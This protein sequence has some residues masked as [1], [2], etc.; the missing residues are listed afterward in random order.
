[1]RMRSHRW[2]VVVGEPAQRS[3]PAPP[4]RVL[5]PRVSTS[6]SSPVPPR[7][8][9][10]PEPPTSTSSPEAPPDRSSSPS[11]PNS[12][13]LAALPRR[14]SFPARPSRVSSPASP[15]STSGAD[16]PRSTSSPAVP[17]WVQAGAAAAAGVAYTTAAPGRAA[18]R[19]SAAIVRFVM[20]RNHLSGSGQMAPWT[21]QEDQLPGPRSGSGWLLRLLLDR[22]VGVADVHIAAGREGV[23]SACIGLLRAGAAL[24]HVDAGR[25]GHGVAT[26]DRHVGLVS[27]YP[28][29]ASLDD[30]D[31]DVLQLDVAAK[32]LR[33]LVALVRLADALLLLPLLVLCA[34]LGPVLG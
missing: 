7:S 11:P 21:G 6:L 16:V 13:S 5:V 14:T 26:A 30:L 23:L 24:Q 3:S 1:M 25:N 15:Q 4:F 27:G 22:D 10:S 31:V 9:S 28:V 2:N 8:S 19:S 32:R 20:S 12:R 34:L 17:V 29:L 33:R 18:A